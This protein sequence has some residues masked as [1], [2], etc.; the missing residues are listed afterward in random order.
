[1]TRKISK[2]MSDVEG[3]ALVRGIFRRRCGVVEGGAGL[4]VGVSLTKTRLVFEES[5]DIRIGK[6]IIPVCVNCSVAS[7]IQKALGT[8]FHETVVS[9]NRTIPLFLRSTCRYLPKP[10]RE[11]NV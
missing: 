7:V 4:E 8:E 5:S 3:D 9:E 11:D 2:R 1:M 10:I 6:S